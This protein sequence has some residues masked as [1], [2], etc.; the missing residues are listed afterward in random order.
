MVRQSRLLDLHDQE[1]SDDAILLLEWL[2]NT[3]SDETEYSKVT[4][5]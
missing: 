4:D 1:P 3:L 2:G 5:R